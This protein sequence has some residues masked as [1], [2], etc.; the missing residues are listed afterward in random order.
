M[1]TPTFK[2]VESTI[3]T[4]LNEIQPT[5]K[6]KAGAWRSKQTGA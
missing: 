3:L 6:N 4:Y 5:S 2:N 1:P